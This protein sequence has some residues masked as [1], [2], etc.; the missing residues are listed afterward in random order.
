MFFN[1]H[2]EEDKKAL[3]NAENALQHMEDMSRQI[4]ARESV[5]HEEMAPWKGRLARNH[6]IQE[7]E[8]LFK[9]NK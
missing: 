8:E 6:F 2:K 5:V 1:S 4:D 3:L 9:G 7:Y